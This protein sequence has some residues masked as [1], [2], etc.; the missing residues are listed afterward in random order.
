MI[1]F[2]VI[3]T[4][5][6]LLQFLNRFCYPFISKLHR[7]KNYRYHI[8]ESSTLSQEMTTTLPQLVVF[9]LDHCLWHPEMYTL[10][11]IPT[12]ESRVYG[13]LGNEDLK[14]VVSL[15]SGREQIKLFP[16]AL[17]ILQKFAEGH[18]PQIR[19]A[20]ASSSNTPKA[21]QIANVALSLLE[22]LPGVSIRDV[23]NMGWEEHESCGSHVQIG[24]T[25]P[26]TSDKSRS[27]FP[28]IRDSTKIGYDSM[29][30]FDDCSWDD[31]VTMVQ[32][33]CEGVVAI[34]TPNGLQESEWFE[35]LETYRIR[36]IKSQKR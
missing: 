6:A 24:R 35:G 27:H 36:K 33:R 7:P 11:E 22:V 29:L 1:S 31:H 10:N 14:G 12:E 30:Y 5:I 13:N 19:L 20:I 16:G 9:D 32:A 28:I 34:R 18:Y 8:S 4:F 3:S 26:L 15:K 25:S 17:K 23:V 2:T 21:V